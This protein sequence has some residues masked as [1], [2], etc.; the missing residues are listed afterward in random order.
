MNS[1]YLIDM[2]GVI[3]KGSK[4][5]HG[6]IEFVEQL[7]RLNTP[8]LFLTNNPEPEFAAAI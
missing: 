5:V 7:K 8:F 6:A 1:G 3:Y 4:L 2:D